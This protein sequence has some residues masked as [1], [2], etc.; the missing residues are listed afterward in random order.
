MNIRTTIVS[1]SLC[2]SA[3]TGDLRPFTTD[4]C[5]LFP[6]GTREQRKLWLACC[7]EH[8]LTYWRG[9]THAERKHADAR[10][11]Q[12]VAQLGEPQTAA[13]MLEGVRVGG[14]PYWP[15]PFRWGYGWPYGRGYKALTP[16]EQAQVDALFPRPPR[17]APPIL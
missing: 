2:V 7:T 14:S 13:L 10:L 1:L 3:C 17:P 11:Q 15:T 16:E 12:C 8:D 5:S 6:E 4:G 9:G